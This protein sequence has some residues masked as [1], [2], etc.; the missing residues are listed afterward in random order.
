MSEA[1]KTAMFNAIRALSL[2]VGS[3]FVQKGWIS[4]ADMQ[5]FVGALLI[6]GP[7]LWD[8]WES[9]QIEKKTEQREMNA[10]NTGMVIADKTV[11]LTPPAVDPKEVKGL[12]EDYKEQVDH[13]IETEKEKL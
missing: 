2:V 10:I 11:G 12:I 1:S 8:Q 3:W 5:I 4:D 9:S 13:I 7:I 6:I